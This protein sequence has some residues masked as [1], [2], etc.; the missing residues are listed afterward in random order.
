[1]EIT[2][3]D[4]VYAGEALGYLAALVKVTPHEYR[5][6]VSHKRDLDK[7]VTYMTESISAYELSLGQDHP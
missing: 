4:T 7:V 1:M 2:R 3:K 5:S 6:A